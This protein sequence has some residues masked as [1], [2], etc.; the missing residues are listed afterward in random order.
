MRKLLLIDEREKLTRQQITDALLTDV[1]KFRD[2]ARKSFRDLKTQ[3]RFMIE[4]I[5]TEDV[6]GYSI[7]AAWEEELLPLTAALEKNLSDKNFYK[8]ISK[9]LFYEEDEA[10][11]IIDELITK[12]KRLVVADFISS[13]YPKTKKNNFN[14]NKK[15]LK[16]ILNKPDEEIKTLKDR[17]V[18]FALCEETARKNN[19]TVVDYHSTL[20]KRIFDTLKIQVER[21]K[22]RNN[23]NK[24]VKNIT[25]R[26]NKLAAANN[27][28]IVDIN[29]NEMDLPI[30]FNLKNQYEKIISAL[31]KIDSKDSI[32][33]LAAFDSITSKY[34]KEIETK[35]TINADQVNLEHTRKTI[36]DIDKILLRIFDLTNLQKNQ[37]LLQTKEYR[38]LCA[39]KLKLKT[40]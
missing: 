29:E 2:I 4:D 36:S 31:P 16:K 10:K 15:Q 27:G 13:F 5:E 28:L 38:E 23:T 32:K 9:N 25:K 18:M 17:L 14:L 34:S 39:E 8:T 3:D 33:R 24:G 37:L 40:K 30:I 1:E 12:R 7:L 6:S 20:I 35:F 11:R 21:T 22:A 19:V 26:I